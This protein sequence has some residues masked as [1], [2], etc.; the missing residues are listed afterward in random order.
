MVNEKNPDNPSPASFI[1][2][3]FLCYGC[4]LLPWRAY[5][6]ISCCPSRAWGG[7]E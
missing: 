1:D 3:N 7:G 6:G 2:T 4:Y 5:S